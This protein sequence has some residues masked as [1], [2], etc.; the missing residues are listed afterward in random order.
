MNLS[1]RGLLVSASLALGLGG[2]GAQAPWSAGQIELKSRPS[3]LL[4]APAAAWNPV[5]A[6]VQSRLEARG[7]QEAT[8]SAG[9][10][11]ELLVYRTALAQA[12]SDWKAVLQYTQAIR[13]L[14]TGESGRRTAGLLNELLARQALEK[15]D[16]AWLRESTRRQVAAMPWDEVAPAIHAI[17]KAL[18]EMQPEAVQQFVASQMDLSTS[19]TK[20]QANLPFVMQLLG[21]RYQL[22]QVIPHRAALL[23]GLDDAIR[24]REGVK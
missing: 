9:E 5:L 17:R 6:T 11:V 10:K 1:F 19:M 8:F 24:E 4:V 21:A 12:R 18:A 20:G 13:E 15:A 3:E 7:Q 22:Q 2:A 23:V 16:D 14:Q